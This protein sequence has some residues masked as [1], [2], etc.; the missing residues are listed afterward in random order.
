VHGVVIFATFSRYFSLIPFNLHSFPFRYSVYAFDFIPQKETCEQAETTKII[1][2]LPSNKNSPELRDPSYRCDLIMQCLHVR[3]QTFVRKR[4][5]KTFKKH[6]RDFHSQKRERKREA[7][8]IVIYFSPFRIID[9]PSVVFISF[10]F[11]INDV[12]KSSRME[13]GPKELLRRTFKCSLH[14]SS[15]DRIVN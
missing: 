7:T 8:E 3:E 10:L 2:E 11:H 4:I 1:Y 13:C 14:H 12:R 9:A 5:K 15:A 6:I